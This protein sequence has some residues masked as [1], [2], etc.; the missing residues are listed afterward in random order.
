MVNREGKLTF[1]NRL[2]MSIALEIGEAIEEGKIPED[3]DEHELRVLIAD[4][5]EASAS[6]S[7]IR[8]E[9]RC[10]RARAFHKHMLTTE[11]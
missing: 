7:E 11:I 2:C 6:V 1:V 3:W 8:K 10:K 4:A 9:P 5:A